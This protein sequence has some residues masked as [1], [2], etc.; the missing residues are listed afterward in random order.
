MNQNISSEK[1]NENKSTNKNKN[2]IFSFL[3]LL[4][5]LFIFSIIM[6]DYIKK[7]LEKMVFFLTKMDIKGDELI[8]LLGVFLMIFAFPITIY[9]FL[10]G[11]YIKNLSRALII[12]TFILTIALTFMFIFSKFILKQYLKSYFE[13]SIKLKA[14]QNFISKNELKN[15]FLLN[16]A[17][18]PNFIKNYC[19]PILEFNWISYLIAVYPQNLLSGF[20]KVFIGFYVNKIKEDLKY[21]NKFSLK[22]FCLFLFGIFLSLS[23]YIYVGF[24]L[25]K[26]IDLLKKEVVLLKKEIILNSEDKNKENYG[27]F[28]NNN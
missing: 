13:N 15:I 18:I 17:F 22:L 25:K 16:L 4:I 6:Q 5:L 24:Q 7:I 26:E 9:E 20:S 19:F 10:I 1:S 12:E 23:I 27:S 21:N 8:I 11:F 14:F 28:N 2:F 3:I